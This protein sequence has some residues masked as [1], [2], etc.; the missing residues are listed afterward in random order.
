MM[1]GLNLSW[2][3]WRPYVGPVVVAAGAWLWI[4]CHLDPAGSY[5]GMPQG[6]GLTVDETFNVQQGVILVEAVRTYGIGLTEPRVLKEV[7]TP[8][9]HLPDHPPLGRWWLGVHHHLVWWLF[10]PKDPDGPFVTACARAGSATAFALTILLVGWCSTA[11]YGGWSGL[12][13]SLGFLLL[14]RMFGHAH[15]AALESMTTLTWT[16]AV[17]AIGMGWD[18]AAPPTWRTAMWTGAIFGLALLTKIQAILI[19]LPILLYGIGRWRRRSLIPFAIWA[20]TGFVVFF[21]GWP[22]LWFDP[23]EH[24]SQYLGGAANRATLSVWLWGE[25]YTD[26][27]VPRLYTLVNWFSTVPVKVHF[28]AWLGWMTSP[29]AKSFDPELQP[30]R[31]KWT[32]GEFLMGAMTFWP[33][34]VFSLPGVP[35]YDC[36]RL[37]LPSLAL[38]MLFF[39]R[40]ADHVVRRFTAWHAPLKNYARAFLLTVTLWQALTV[41]SVGPAY[42]SYYTGALGGTRRAQITKLEMNYWGDAVSRSL[43]EQLTE[44]VPRGTT[45][46]MT[47]VLHQFQCA[48]LMRQSPILR[49]H[50]IKLVALDPQ[51]DPAPEYVL[52]FRR[53]ADLPPEWRGTPDG[54][55]V[56]AEVTRSGVQLAAVY[57]K[58]RKSEVEVRK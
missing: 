34:L 26:R 42:L 2:T 10:P 23:V 22:W 1:R 56:A 39:G 54:Y 29:A 14:P 5:P 50:G 46:A 28:L 9:L 16:A 18:R 51:I 45:V 11:W 55:S 38:L 19:P 15:L 48:E 24:L 6:P 53:F 27:T 7:F 44:I 4:V 41:G 47:P 37:W 8:P 30:F 40:G 31:Q 17:L 35:V 13:T 49:R 52:L 36:E 32:P 3:A 12:M 57:Q 21:I 43:L 58:S 33:L 20:G 25:Q